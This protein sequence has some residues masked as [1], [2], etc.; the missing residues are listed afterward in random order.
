MYFYRLLNGQNVKSLEFLYNNYKN[1]INI[2]RQYAD[3]RKLCIGCYL[4]ETD[5]LL[6][7]F[8]HR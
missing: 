6:C 7:R 8:C 3:L 5:D 1:V 2:S 4:Q